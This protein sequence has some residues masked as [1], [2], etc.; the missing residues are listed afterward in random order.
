MRRI[1]V[2]N[3]QRLLQVKEGAG[4]AVEK[5]DRAGSLKPGIYDLTRVLL[6][7]N[8]KQYDGPILHSEPDGIYQV[9]EHGIVKHAFDW[10]Y[11]LPI[12]GQVKTLTYNAAGRMTMKYGPNLKRKKVAPPKI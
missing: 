10:F 11:T 1:V 3:G 8:N 5:V 2:M 9:T 12:A 7:E 6:P 4:W